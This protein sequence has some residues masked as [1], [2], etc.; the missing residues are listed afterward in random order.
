M[1]LRGCCD[2][3]ILDE[4]PRARIGPLFEERIP[5]FPGSYCR[6]PLELRLEIQHSDL[7]RSSLG[8]PSGKK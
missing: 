3:R 2:F 7:V 5:K 1:F 4:A 6:N 8:D